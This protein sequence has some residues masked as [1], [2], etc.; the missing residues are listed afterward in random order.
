MAKE[1]P[2][3]EHEHVTLVRILGKDLRG[4]RKVIAGLRGIKGVSWAISNAI[5]VSKK[6][7]PNKKIME[8]N[9]EEIARIEQFFSN[10][11]IPSFLKN[12]RKDFDDGLDKHMNG[13]DLRLRGEFDIKRLKK[14]KSYKGI[15]HAAGQPVRGQ[16]T[17]SHFRKNKSKTGSIGAKKVEEKK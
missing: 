5:C 14:I 6:I 4:D 1:R 7:D 3:S 16:R 10:P 11:E 12:R 8:L 2:I 15:R 17:R 9:S 13:A